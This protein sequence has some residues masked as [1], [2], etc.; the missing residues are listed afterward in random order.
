MSDN[1]VRVLVEVSSEE[2]RDNALKYS[3]APNPTLIKTRKGFI[4]GM[5]IDESDREELSQLSGIVNV[6]DDH[7]V[8][9]AGGVGAC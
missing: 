9:I 5:Q 6:E 2:A 4:I 3:K 8:T 1:L 7:E